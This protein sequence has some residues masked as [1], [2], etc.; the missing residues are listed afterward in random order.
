VRISETFGERI[1]NIIF[2]ASGNEITDMSFQK[3][4]VDGRVLTDDLNPIE[5]YLEQARAGELYYRR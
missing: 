3:A 1:Q 2:L 5:V 4:P